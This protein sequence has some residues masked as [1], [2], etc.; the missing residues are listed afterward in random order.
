MKRFLFAVECVALAGVL[1]GM[2]SIDSSIVGSTLLMLVSSLI[3]YGVSKL[4]EQYVDT[5]K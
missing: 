1:L 4:E 2:C 3:L 5:K